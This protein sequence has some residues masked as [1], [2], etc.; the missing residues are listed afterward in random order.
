M[1]AW[2]RIKQHLSNLL[3]E[4][5]RAVHNDFHQLWIIHIKACPLNEFVKQGLSSLCILQ[6]IFSLCLL[7]PFKLHIVSLEDVCLF[8][9]HILVSLFIYLTFPPERKDN[10]P[11]VTGKR[12][13][14]WL[15]LPQI[16]VLW[17]YA[18]LTDVRQA[19]GVTQWTERLIAERCRIEKFFFLREQ[20]VSK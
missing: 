15:N 17:R 12:E 19:A 3:P 7:Q 18:Q 13:A 11:S 8:V 6:S 10:V 1:V 5:L 4:L 2:D 20:L 16:H 14:L 9:S